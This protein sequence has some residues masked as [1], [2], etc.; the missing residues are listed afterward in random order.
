MANSRTRFKV[1]ESEVTD[2]Q[3]EP[4]KAIDMWQR[5]L[6]ARLRDLAKVR[7]DT[8]NATTE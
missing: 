7:K 1:R 8:Q 4:N 3:W 2:P 5:M 6:S